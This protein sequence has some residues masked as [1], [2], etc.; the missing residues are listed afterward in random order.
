MNSIPA[1]LN[2]SKEYDALVLFADEDTDFG[3]K[4]IY[5]LEK[6]GLKVSKC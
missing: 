3:T 6:R 2:A 5:E 4:I 1:K